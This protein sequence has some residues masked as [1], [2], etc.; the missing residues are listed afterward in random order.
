MPLTVHP[1]CISG[2]VI[3]PAKR[4]DLDRLVELL[5]ALQDHLEAS[6]L[7]L[8]RMK[9]SVRAQLKSQLS[10]RLAADDSCALVAEHDEDGV[11]GVIFGRVATNKRYVPERAGLVDQAFV[12][13]DHRR[14]G[15]GSLLVAELC[16]F[17]ASKGVDDLS[18]RYVSGNDDA[19]AFWASLG[20]APRIVTVGARRQMVEKQATEAPGS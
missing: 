19:A 12:R 5:L 18:L 1:D 3:R 13:V 20:F 7:E 8:W 16:R 2:Y 15:V 4:S 14:K 11:I 6:N 10:A 9:S 17:F